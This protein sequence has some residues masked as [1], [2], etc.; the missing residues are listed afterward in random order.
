MN[1]KL[2]DQN[3]GKQPDPVIMITIITGSGCFHSVFF[4]SALFWYLVQ[5]L[6]YF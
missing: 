4:I 6:G 3:F 5:V 1:N 2:N